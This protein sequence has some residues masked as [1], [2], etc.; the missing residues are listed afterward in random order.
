MTEASGTRRVAPLGH[1]GSAE[2]HGARAG[3]V[4]VRA[5]GFTHDWEWFGSHLYMV[6][7]GMV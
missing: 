5:P 1:G 2:T 7:W 3:V 4:L 6:I